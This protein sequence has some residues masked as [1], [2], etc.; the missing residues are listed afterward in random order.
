MPDSITLS[1]IDGVRIVVPNSLDLITPYV[2]IE[3]QDWFEDEV[4]FL[5]RLLGPGRKVID[6]GANYGIYT[7]CMAKAVG[8]EG[9]V[10]AFEPSSSCAALLEEGVA[11]NGF[12]HVIVVRSRY[13]ASAVPD[14][15]R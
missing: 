12:E 8:A 11:A 2:L 5:R 9:F 3:Q 6:I 4:R 14:V 15:S 1:L 10:W 13:P 7:L